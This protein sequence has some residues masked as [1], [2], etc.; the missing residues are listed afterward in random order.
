MTKVE[1]QLFF[2]ANDGEFGSEL[3]KSDGTAEGTVLVKDVW[4]GERN[5][6]PMDL[7]NVNGQLFFTVD[8]PVYGREL[9]KSD[10]TEAG[11]LMVKDILPGGNSYRVGRLTAHSAF[12]IFYS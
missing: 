5:S 10:G 9:W 1:N 3:W 12:V 7:T 11:T 6:N 8:D 4:P 2:S